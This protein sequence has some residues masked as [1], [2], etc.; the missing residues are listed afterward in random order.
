M[1]GKLLYIRSRH[2]G[3]G[4]YPA[5]ACAPHFLEIIDAADLPDG[6]CEN[7]HDLI[8]IPMQSDEVMLGRKSAW[9][10]GIWDQGGA[11]LANDV[12]AQPY[13]PF[14]SP[15]VPVPQPSLKDF[16]VARLMPHPA[17]D[18]LPADYYV[19]GGMLGVY[20]VGHNPPPAGAIT[21]NTVGQGA[22]AI[23]W[24][25]DGPKGAL[26]F[27]HGGPDISSFHSDPEHRPNLT[28]RLIDWIMERSHEHR[29][30]S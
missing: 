24:F 8:I 7:R 28:H 11:F 4:P 29:L 26:F 22:F 25:L 16:E 19:F 1:K 5:Y 23:D 20:G 17:F 30:H 14:L 10:Q 6:A 27:C 18:P 21:V 2:R 3:E 13:L 9:L 12:I 15:F